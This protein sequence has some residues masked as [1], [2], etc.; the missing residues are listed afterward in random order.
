MI[1]L[2][3]RI[4]YSGPSLI[5]LTQTKYITNA[6]NALGT[7]LPHS[8]YIMLGVEIFVYRSGV[9]GERGGELK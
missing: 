5:H 6:T 2:C 4:L 7:K 9:W 1:V 3:A 8:L